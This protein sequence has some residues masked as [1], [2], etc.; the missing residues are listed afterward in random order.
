M[1]IKNAKELALLLNIN[2]DHLQIVWKS[3]MRNE[4]YPESLTFSCLDLQLTQDEKYYLM[5]L[6]LTSI[7]DAVM[8]SLKDK[9]DA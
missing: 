7:S 4:G 2:F 5:Y 6:G 8:N 3:F 1:K 9:K